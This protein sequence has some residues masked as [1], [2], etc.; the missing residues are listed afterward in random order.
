VSEWFST[1][2]KKHKGFVFQ[3]KGIAVGFFVGAT[4]WLGQ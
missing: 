3:A 4:V 2:E 1:T